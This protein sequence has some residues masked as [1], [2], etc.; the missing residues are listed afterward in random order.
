MEYVC[1]GVR[2]TVLAHPALGP[3]GVSLGAYTPLCSW[4]YDGLANLILSFASL[5]ERLASQEL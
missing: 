1:F 3:S 2:V 4:T 5:F